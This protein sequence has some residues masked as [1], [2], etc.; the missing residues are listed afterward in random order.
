[1][2]KMQK[3]LSVALIGFLLCPLLPIHA[4]AAP[5]AVY[6]SFTSGNDSHTGNGTEASPYNLLEDAL[7]AVADGGTIYI[8]GSKAFVN[9][10]D[11]APLKITKNVTIKQAS[12]TSSRP[13]LEMRKGG[14]VL[15]GNVTFENVVL[16][17]SNAY[18]PIICANGY[19]LTLNSVSYSSSTRVIHLAGGS[20]YRQINGQVQLDSPTPGSHSR[21]V[22]SGSDSKF[23]NIYAGSINGSFDKAVDITLTGISGSNIGAIYA[24]GAQEGYYNGTNFLDPENEPEYPTPYASLFPVYGD[25][26]I[27]LTNST[28]RTLDGKTGTGANAALT[29]SAQYDYAPTI[30]D[31]A[32]LTVASGSFSPQ[33][34]ADGEYILM[35]TAVTLKSGG[36]LNLSGLGDCYVGSLTG[37]GGELQLSPTSRVAILQGCSGTA[38]LSIYSN[39]SATYDHQYIYANTDAD[40]FQFTPN[41]AQSDMKLI[42]VE[43]G[44]KTTKKDG[45]VSA[46]ADT[47]PALTSF[48]LPQ[49]QMQVKDTELN[50]RGLSIPV[51][52]AFTE[53]S[54]AD[55]L[56]TIPLV[57]TV[58]Y[59]NKTYAKEQKST[60]SAYAGYYALTISEL[61]LFLE[62]GGDSNGQMIQVYPADFTKTIPA[63]VYTFKITAPLD[64]GKTVTQTLT[65]TVEDDSPEKTL[66]SVDGVNSGAVTVTFRNLTDRTISNGVMIAA[67]YSGGRFRAMRVA[68]TPV[69]TAKDETARIT[70]SFSGV[71]YDEIRIFLCDNLT[72][73]T[74]LC[75]SYTSAGT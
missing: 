44:W 75:E 60:E 72:S 73:K 13:T 18:R 74:P 63:G 49:T 25:V 3:M 36:K 27:S 40:V 57:Y 19:T 39:A 14:I 56:G 26:S 42:H 9:S 66:W 43:D 55:D 35:E 58:T 15:G 22:I 10:D 30:S 51:N 64:G 23:G 8:S 28:V 5:T 53:D 34:A 32:T 2:K 54:W 16:S 24:C 11:N 29:V 50:T 17:F 52:A 70:F 71:Q 69:S 45:S 20:L 33:A 1:M 21:I 61:N 12:G 48:S 46:N 4:A 65:L 6:T 31:F 67:A 38:T 41:S 59:N 7:N 37:Q 62:P 68:S 47:T